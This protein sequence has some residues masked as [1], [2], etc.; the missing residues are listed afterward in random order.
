MSRGVERSGRRK[1][2][3][4][5][6]IIIL[7]ALVIVSLLIYWEQTALLYFVSTLLISAVL[8][9]VAV[10]DLEGKD[11]QLAQASEGSGS[12]EGRKP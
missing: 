6:Y 8:V 3:G 1:W 11:R 12:P 9:I 4:R 7:S 5:T 2:R 10:A